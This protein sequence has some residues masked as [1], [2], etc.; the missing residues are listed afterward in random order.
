MMHIS[1]QILAGWFRG[2]KSPKRVCLTNMQDT[3]LG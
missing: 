2:L 1:W 3:R